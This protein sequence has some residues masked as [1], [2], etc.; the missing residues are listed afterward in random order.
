LT[1]EDAVEVRLD[2]EPVVRSGSSV[3]DWVRLIVALAALVVLAMLL[4]GAV[5]PQPQCGGG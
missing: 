5:S 3:A 4:L 2:Q 1:D